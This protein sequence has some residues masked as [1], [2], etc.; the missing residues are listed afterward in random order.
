VS[1]DDDDVDM[2][3]ELTMT[4]EE[5]FQFGLDLLRDDVIKHHTATP[6]PPPAAAAR[7][8]CT[9]YWFKGLNGIAFYWK[10]I[11]KLRSATCRRDHA[12]LPVN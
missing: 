10:L 9:F 12:V 3:A 8:S 4:A 2:E 1:F 6:S 11:S 5:Q 7:N